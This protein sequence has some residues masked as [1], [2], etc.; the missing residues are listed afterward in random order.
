MSHLKARIFAVLLVLVGAFLIH[1]NWHQLS[2]DGNYSV[3]LAAFAPLVVVGGIFLLAFPSKFGK[4]VTTQDKVITI[5]VFVIG[6][7]AGLVNWYLMDPGFF[8]K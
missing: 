3:K 7:A 5:L 2:Q 4:P 1:M 8:V 6:I